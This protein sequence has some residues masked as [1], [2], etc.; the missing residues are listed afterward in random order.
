MGNWNRIAL[1]GPII[2]YGER[3][4]IHCWNLLD[5]AG[6]ES[7]YARRIPT[8]RCWK[9]QQIMAGIDRPRQFSAEVQRLMAHSLDA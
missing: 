3:L 9:N 7:S 8:V 6:F 2:G 5:A 4:V 1:I